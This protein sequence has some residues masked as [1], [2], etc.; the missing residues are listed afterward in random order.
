MTLIA[1]VCGRS[2]RPLPALTLSPVPGSRHSGVRQRVCNRQAAGRDHLKPPE[3]QN[4]QCDDDQE[5]CA[6]RSMPSLLTSIP[7]I[8]MRVGDE[9]MLALCLRRYHP[10]GASARITRVFGPWLRASSRSAI[11]LPARAGLGRAAAGTRGRRRGA[12]VRRARRALPATRAPAPPPP[13]GGHREAEYH[14][15]R[16]ELR[17]DHSP[18]GGSGEAARAREA[19]NDLSG[20]VLGPHPAR[21]PEASRRREGGHH[22]ALFP[23]RSHERG[24]PAGSGRR[25]IRSVGRRAGRYH[26]RSAASTAPVRKLFCNFRSSGEGPPGSRLTWSCSGCFSCMF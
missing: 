4:Q 3:R 6:H 9:R 19:P 22:P 5:D 23:R 24:R 10:S 16:G 11:G 7:D 14:D 18:M 26:S 1:V 17:H 2:P 20:L 21:A 12:V 8:R 15:Q 25:M 13:A